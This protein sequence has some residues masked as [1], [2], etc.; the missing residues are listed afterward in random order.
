M[1]HCAR[2]SCVRVRGELVQVVVPVEGVVLLQV[3]ELLQGLVD[4][5]DTDERGKGFLREP[6]DVADKGAS[7]G[8]HQQDAEES[9]PQTNAGPQGQVGQTVFSEFRETK[10]DKGALESNCITFWLFAIATMRE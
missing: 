4:E 2:T 1:G 5:Y 8:G 3:D 6:R 7:V 9:C 10:R